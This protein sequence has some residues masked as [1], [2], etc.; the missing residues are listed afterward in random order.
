[1]TFFSMTFLLVFLPAGLLL[2][3]GTPNRFKNYT[4]LGLSLLFYAALGPLELLVMAA[5]VVF[6]YM[7]ASLIRYHQG[8]SRVTR[9][10]LFLSVLKSVSL[11][12]FCMVRSQLEGYSMPVGI[13]VYTLSA[14][15]YVVD[16]Y[17]GEAPYERSLC[18]FLLYNCFFGKIF[19][20]PYVKYSLIRPQLRKKQLSLSSISTGLVLLIQGIAKKVVLA[21][22]LLLTY[23]KVAQVDAS[24]ASATTLSSWLLLL[25]LVLGIYFTLS[26]Y[27]DV[28]RGLGQIFCFKLPR[29]FSYPLHSSSVREFVNH[30]NTT[31]VE[32]LRRYVYR[33]L[34]GGRYG[35]VSDCFNTLLY[36][37]LFGVWF[38]F[39]PNLLL[40]GGVLALFMLGERYLY[41]RLLRRLPAVFG[42]VYTYAALLVSFCLPA[43][44]TPAGSWQLLKNLF[45]FH[46]E[47]L[48]NDKIVYILS[49]SYWVLLLGLV[50]S[51]ALLPKLSALLKRRAPA[52]ANILSVFFNVGLLVVSVMFII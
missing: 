6:D 43:K 25:S 45:S 39:S 17:Q 16:L 50:L 9:T 52:A 12:L 49:Q 31:L 44:G 24:R 28:A 2:Y 33:P 20:G 51:F 19:V 3:Y 14:T 23:R 4:L 35:V 15:G 29:N 1:M 5:S 40:F 36:M 34:G 32:Y 30:F 22:N 13:L 8:N 48:V 10:A 7:M 46:Q 27:C 42:R 26:A 11:I 37:L 41:G 18:N 38:S 47:R 21:D